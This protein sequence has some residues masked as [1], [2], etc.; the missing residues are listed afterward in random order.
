MNMTVE[1][2][3][4]P[5]G[6]LLLKVVSDSFASHAEFYRGDAIKLA[7]KGLIESVGKTSN[8]RMIHAV[9]TFKRDGGDVVVEIRRTDGSLVPS[10][11]H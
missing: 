4:E 6:A 5:D 10:R 2:D 11:I 8:F 1:Y 3:V 7:L 9:E